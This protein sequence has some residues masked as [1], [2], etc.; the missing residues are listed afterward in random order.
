M[1][2][3][4]SYF[5]A[6]KSGFSAGVT[7]SDIL[8]RCTIVHPV[9][10]SY[11]SR[12][13]TISRDNTARAKLALDLVAVRERGR[14]LGNGVGHRRLKIRVDLST[15]ETTCLTWLTIGAHAQEASGHSWPLASK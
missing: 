7:E 10:L 2:A 13:A 14:K 4:V 1:S 9:A 5:P 3:I 11:I 6:A 15:S 12:A 8:L